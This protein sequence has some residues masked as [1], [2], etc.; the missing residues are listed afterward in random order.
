[1]SAKKHPFSKYKR[2]SLWHILQHYVA[3]DAPEQV[4]LCLDANVQ[5]EQDFHIAERLV[6][7]FHGMNAYEMQNIEPERRPNEGVWEMSKHEFHGEAYRLL[8]DSDVKGF[9]R[10]MCNAMRA[11]L[12]HGLGPG[13]QVFQA[14]ASKGEGREAN[15]LI[16]KDRLASLAEALGCLPY[17]GPEQGPYGEAILRPIEALAA[18]IE[19]TL[20]YEIYRPTVMGNFGIQYRDGVIDVRVPEDAYCTFSVRRLMQNQQCKRVVEIG[21]GFGGMAFQFSRSGL[22]EYTIVDLPIINLVQGYFLMK[23][24]GGDE[25]KLFGENIP[26]RRFN[27]LPYWEFFNRDRQFDL[28][29]NRDSLPEIPRARVEEYLSEI[30]A[31]NCLLYSI[32]QEG[33]ALAGQVDLRQINVHKMTQAFDNLPCQSRSPY[34]IRKGYVEAIYGKR[35]LGTHTIAQ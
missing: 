31:R 11:E 24:F 35:A 9:A 7:A 10:L 15:V 5:D 6:N 2:G 21:G 29:F 27:V 28:V 34:W 14:F 13:L 32:N 25:V 4:T 16:L 19:S 33:E 18:M 20:G 1:M 17:E 8:F 22:S 30:S 3:G 23:I 26:D 12:C